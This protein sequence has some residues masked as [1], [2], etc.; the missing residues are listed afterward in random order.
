MVEKD[1]RHL[2]L[3][4]KLG[5]ERLHAESFSRVMAPVKNIQAKFLRQRVSPVRS[6]TR[7]K[8]IHAFCRR[9][10][11]FRARAAGNDADATANFRAAWNHERIG[12]RNMMQTAGEV[13][14]RNVRLTSKANGLAIA[15]KKRTELFQPE[16][17]TEQSIVADFRMGVQRQV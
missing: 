8:G 11:E 1:P 4:G 17:G 7:N 13:C 10:F 5:R 3:P 2:E 6:F 15:K 12:A 14:P 9:L 16:R